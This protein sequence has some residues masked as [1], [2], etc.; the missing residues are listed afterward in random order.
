M[1]AA[2]IT[3]PEDTLRTQVRAALAVA[4]ISQAEVAR[5]LGCST[6]HLNQMITGRAVL[7]L[8][9]AQQILALCG[10]HVVVSLALL[11]TADTTQETR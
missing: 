5:R 9:W 2:P 3:R 1:T 11:P 4:G 7:T 10:M 6:K 8:D